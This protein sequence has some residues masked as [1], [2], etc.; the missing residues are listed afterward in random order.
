MT[1]AGTDRFEKLPDDVVVIILSFLPT[2]VEVARTSI[3]SKRWRNLWH[4]VT[5]LDFDA[6]TVTQIDPSK[7]SHASMYVAWVNQVIDARATITGLPLVKEFHT[8]FGLDATQGLHIDRWLIFAIENQVER[9]HLDFKP[10]ENNIQPINQYKL[11]EETWYGAPSGISSL[12]SLKSIFLSCVNVSKQ[13]IE[14]ILSSCPLLEEMTLNFAGCYQELIVS[15]VPPLQLRRLKISLG[16]EFALTILD[17]PNLTSLYYESPKFNPQKI[18]V[19][20]LTDLTIG[21]NSR[22]NEPIMNY[23]DHFWSYLPQLEKLA[24]L[25]YKPEIFRINNMPELVTLKFLKISFTFGD[26]DDVFV[27][28]M[29]FICACPLLETLALEMDSDDYIPRSARKLRRRQRRLSRLQNLVKYGS[30]RSLKVLEFYG[31][32]GETFDQEV[33]KCLVW[34]TPH[35]E[36]L[37]LHLNYESI[38]PDL[39]PLDMELYKILKEKAEQLC[40]GSKSGIEITITS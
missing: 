20:M 34:N 31:A 40:Q 32:V 33:T 11:S 13:F 18:N 8:W 39:W 23:L 19:P 1:A 22:S 9:L 16:K 10:Y 27:E 21:G 25:V 36:K 15:G 35:L 30:F 17:A 38:Y 28:I 14:F 24:L 26:C 12:K 3:L 29:N 6:T 7:Q 5:R 4:H 2:L 37:I